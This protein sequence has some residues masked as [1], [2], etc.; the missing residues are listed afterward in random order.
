MEL[1]LLVMLL[2]EWLSKNF[3]TYVTAPIVALSLK[4]KKKKIERLFIGKNSVVLNKTTMVY[5]LK[6]PS[7]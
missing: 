1:K 4:K 7:T 6:A 5:K 3:L 2:G